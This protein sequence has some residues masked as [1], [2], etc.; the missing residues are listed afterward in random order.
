MTQK[1]E[2]REIFPE[3]LPP[4]RVEHGSTAT[5]NIVRGSGGKLYAH[6][7]LLVITGWEG[8]PDHTRRKGHIEDLWVHPHFWGNGFGRKLM[9]E[10]EA[11]ALKHGCRKIYLT[12][13]PIEERRKAREL[14]LELGYEETEGR[15][16]KQLTGERK[17]E[18]ERTA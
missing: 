17:K 1:E 15:F 7:R 14:Y 2:V 6:V 9:L 5:Y 12:C 3:V 8:G 18:K 4:S 13:A 16:V 11:E 10:A